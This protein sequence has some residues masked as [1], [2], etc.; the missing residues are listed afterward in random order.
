MIG[1]Q[2]YRHSYK[3]ALSKYHIWLESFEDFFGLQI[4]A[5]DFGH[6]GQVLA[7]SLYIG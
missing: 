2:A 4:S 7:T 5:A 1:R 3:P 6:I